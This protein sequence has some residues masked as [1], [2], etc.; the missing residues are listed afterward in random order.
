MSKLLSLQEAVAECVVDESLAF[1]SWG[2]GEWYCV[3]SRALVK[4]NKGYRDSDGLELRFAFE[5]LTYW[6]TKPIAEVEKELGLIRPTIEHI[7]SKE[8][9]P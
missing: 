6:H 4:V 5:I 2:G 1:Q 3:K 8:P 7:T 9:L